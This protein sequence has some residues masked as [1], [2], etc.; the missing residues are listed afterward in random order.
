MFYTRPSAPV[1]YD[2]GALFENTNKHIQ[3]ESSVNILNQIKTTN[4]DRLKRVST[5]ASVIDTNLFAV[6]SLRG[7]QNLFAAALPL[8]LEVWLECEPSDLSAGNIV[9]LKMILNTVRLLLDNLEELELQHRMNTIDKETLEYRNLAGFLKDKYLKSI[10]KY[11]LAHFPFGVKATYGEK[12]RT[13]NYIR[14]IFKI[15]YLTPL[16]YLT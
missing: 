6:N 11:I 12:V 4:S 8:L 16:I 14:K 5:S 7:L 2:F 13:V 15:I 3:E 1:S 9:N 10:Q